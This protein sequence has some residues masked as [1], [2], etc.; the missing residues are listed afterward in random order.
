MNGT[1]IIY[2]AICAALG[3]VG[4]AGKLCDKDRNK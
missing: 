3:I 2:A 1:W 4:I